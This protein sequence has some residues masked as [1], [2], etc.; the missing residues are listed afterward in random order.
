MFSVLFITAA[1]SLYRLGAGDASLVYANILNL[2]ARIIFAV[3]FTKTF[4]ASKGGRN[5][6]SVRDILPS[7]HLLF[8]SFV[9]WGS[10]AYD[11]RSRDV[12]RIVR[13][14]GKR[15]LLEASVVQ[16]IGIG[17]A[18]AVVW[19]SYWWVSSGRRKSWRRR[20]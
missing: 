11:G 10:V 3:L 17:S 8:V 19:L 2:L 5:L 20:S 9:V 16:H 12:E 1:I 18:L 6:V 7:F 14:T 15:S 4:F 13:L